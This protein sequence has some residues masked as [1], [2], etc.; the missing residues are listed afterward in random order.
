MIDIHAHILPSIDDGA[1]NASET[2]DMIREAEKNGI[3]EIIATSHYVKDKYDLNKE[4]RKIIIDLINQKLEEKQINVKIHVGAEIL[5]YPEMVEDIIK[6]E[7]P[8]LGESRYVLFELPFVGKVIYL[9][10]IIEELLKNGYRPI[11]AHPERYEIVKEN[12]GIIDKWIEK[13]VYLQGNISSI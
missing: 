13:G 5:I 2:F 3:T 7:V 12:P 6:G 11:L 10:N 8:T 1:R 4:N 9:D